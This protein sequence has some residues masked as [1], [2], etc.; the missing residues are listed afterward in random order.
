MTLWTSRTWKWWISCV[1]RLCFYC[2]RGSWYETTVAPLLVLV[3]TS[4]LLSLLTTSWHITLLTAE[5]AV[6]LA[7]LFN[8]WTCSSLILP[9]HRVKNFNWRSKSAPKSTVPTNPQINSEIWRISSVTVKKAPFNFSHCFICHYWILP[10]GVSASTEPER[11]V[12]ICKYESTV[13]SSFNTLFK[14][15]ADK[16]SFTAFNFN[17]WS[18]KQSNKAITYSST[19]RIWIQNII[20]NANHLWWQFFWMQNG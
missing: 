7:D 15:R 9:L 3:A 11:M 13:D 12:D 16:M 19:C 1:N 5:L 4:F 6:N 10:S 18:L 14:S 17:C 20:F 8:T 2:S